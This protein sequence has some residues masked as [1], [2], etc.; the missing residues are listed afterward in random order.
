MAAVQRMLNALRNALTEMADEDLQSLQDLYNGNGTSSAAAGK[1]HIF[2]GA[3]R[4]V[5]EQDLRYWRYPP[6]GEGRLR[7]N[8]LWRAYKE[9]HNVKDAERVEY[10][11]DK[12]WPIQYELHRLD[13][14]YVPCK[15]RPDN[16]EDMLEQ[17]KRYCARKFPVRWS[18]DWAI[19]VENNIGEF[20][21]TLRTLLDINCNH[22]LAIFFD[23]GANGREI[24]DC[25]EK[26]CWRHFGPHN[27]H[28]QGWSLLAVFLPETLG[29][30]G[31][32][33]PRG[34]IWR[35][36]DGFLPLESTG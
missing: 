21:M 13:C 8:A 7:P 5:R 28:P 9:L 29:S 35:E 18:L 23:D 20:C 19:E 11:I 22:R 2:T 34:F 25:F 1:T 12:E 26:Y 16:H 10:V 3:K 14:I 6:K 17:L 33:R 36:E 4:G 15:K 31:D 30:A 32:I 27:R 24:T